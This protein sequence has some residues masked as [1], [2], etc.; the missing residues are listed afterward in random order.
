MAQVL[1]AEIR[2][3][4]KGLVRTKAQVYLA[5]LSVR[6]RKRLAILQTRMKMELSFNLDLA[7]RNLGNWGSGAPPVVKGP[8]SLFLILVRGKTFCNRRES[9]ATAR[10]ASA[11]N[12]FCPKGTEP[13][14]LAL[15]SLFVFLI[16]F[17]LAVSSCSTMISGR[18]LYRL[19]Y[20]RCHILILECTLS[21]L[22]LL[23]NSDVLCFYK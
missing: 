5:S 3:G 23:F 8:W 2:P 21:C 22:F 19:Y 20:S 18:K 7:Y 1:P 4:W 14:Y 17:L 11:N 9:K 15:I 6:K 13:F 16:H 12:R 10:M